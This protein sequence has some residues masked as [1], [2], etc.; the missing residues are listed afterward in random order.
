MKVVKIS[1]LFTSGTGVGD[2]DLAPDGVSLYERGSASTQY[3]SLMFLGSGIVLSGDVEEYEERVDFS[4]VPGYFYLG[5]R[6][7]YA[8]NEKLTQVS[9]PVPSGEYN[10]IELQQ[11]PDG[12][13]PSYLDRILYLSDDVEDK[14]YGPS[15][16]LLSSL[17]S[18]SLESLDVPLDTVISSTSGVCGGLGYRVDYSYHVSG[19]VISGEVDNYPGHFSPLQRFSKCYEYWREDDQV[20]PAEYEYDFKTNSVI[21]HKSGELTDEYIVEFEGTNEPFS[22]GLDLSTL[23]SYPENSIICLSTSETVSGEVGSVQVYTSKK[24]M[25]NETVTVSIEVKSINENRLGNI[26][27]DIWLKRKDMTSTGTDLYR[28][29]EPLLYESGYV[30]DSL[31]IDTGLPQ[32]ASVYENELYVS[33]DHRIGGGCWVRGAGYLIVP[34]DYQSDTP[35]SGPGYHVTAVTDDVGFAHVQYIAPSGTLSTIELEL[36]VTAGGVVGS[37]DITLMSELGDVKAFVEDYYLYG[38]TY[39]S[40]EVVSSGDIDIPVPTDCVSPSSMELYYAS[41][42][43]L[44]MYDGNDTTAYKPA[45]FIYTEGMAPYVRFESVSPTDAFVIKYPKNVDVTKLDGRNSYGS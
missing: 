45:S 13:K 44:D 32:Q 7:F 29:G 43:L 15:P 36:E 20:S 42:Y 35:M 22:S 38:Y 9:H 27:L 26:D 3:E 1:N 10:V 4:V 34:G 23:V 24:R 41:D 17:A 39:T 33:S 14:R 5:D 28:E 11:F 31:E 30:Y 8:Y 12:P 19:E 2:D 6:E 16:I 21:I 25:Y 37:A 40:G 18:G